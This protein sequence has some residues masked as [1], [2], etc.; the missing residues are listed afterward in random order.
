MKATEMIDTLQK[1][2]EIKGDLEIG[3]VGSFIGGVH[4]EI[5]IFT[6]DN[7]YAD[8]CNFFGEDSTKKD[9]D[10]FFIDTKD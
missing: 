4:T 3:I 7:Y 9:W 6:S 10:I 8:G 2:I 1:L 5:D